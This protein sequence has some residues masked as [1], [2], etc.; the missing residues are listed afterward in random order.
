MRLLHLALG[1]MAA[2]LL[3]APLILAQAAQTPDAALGHTQYENNCS[4]CHGGDARGGEHGPAIN[5]RLTRLDESQLTTLIHQGLPSRGMPSF[6]N[7][8]GQPLVN[9]VAFLRT[10]KSGEPE[11]I[12]RRE[13]TTSTGAK[14][15]GIVLNQS[16]QDL[17]LRTADNRIHLLRATGST[18]REVTSQQDWAT[19]N[20]DPSGNR[21]S[22]LAQITKTNIDRL[23]PRWIF[24]FP[25]AAFLETTPLVIEGTMYV[26]SANECYALDAGN[27]R[28]LWHFRRPRTKG[29]TGGGAAGINRGVARAGDRLFMVT[30]DAHLLALNRF[31]GQL[32]WETVMADS[33]QNYNATS[34]PLV[35]NDLVVCGTAGGEEGVR[36]FMAAFRQ[37]TGKEA[38]RFWTVPKPGDPE[39]ATWRGKAIEHGSA[40]AWF[41]GSFDPALNMVYWQTG[42]PGPDYN[43]LERLGD[44]LY[45]DSVVALDAITGKLKWHFQFTP[46]DTHDWDATEPVV[47]LDTAWKGQPRKL[48]L[49]ANRNGFFY[50]FDRTN[51]EVLLTKPFV[52]KLNWATAI[53]PDHRP[54]LA[55]PETVAGGTRVCPSQDG[56]TNWYSTSF[57]PATGLYY[58]QTVEKCD[59]YSQSPAEWQAGQ[60]YL[61]GS[62]QSAPGDIPQKVL[63]AIDIQT[64]KVVWELPQFGRGDSWGGTLVTESGVLFFCDDSGMLAAAD[65]RTGKPIWSFHANQ[66]WKASP[67]TYQFD[68]QQYLAI[69]SG[70]TVTAFA[71]LK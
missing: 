10:L 66:N 60:S 24:T 6:P 35:V 54:V 43:G 62:Q 39:A 16:A 47:L 42:N 19:Y 17:A 15:E 64:G 71:L 70:Q 31:T 18:F 59:V 12:V 48:L 53:G 13:V 29:L 25:G 33:H 58:L 23:A 41:T 38:W 40:A 3:E 44:N 7:L 32:E 69:A 51:G 56:A 14:L 50:V 36:G 37:D 55:P 45:S 63:R 8:T 65:A 28:R 57:L 1:L 67:M 9:L 21:Y 61:G 46:H 4:I 27:G 49:Q 30:D 52:K 68:E 26:S 2:G 20:G 22:K 34:A 11:P 5:E